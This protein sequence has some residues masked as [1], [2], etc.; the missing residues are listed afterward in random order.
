MAAVVWS[1][2]GQICAFWYAGGRET[3]TSPLWIQDIPEF[4][5]EF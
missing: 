1:A 3:A 2:V 4:V 5:M